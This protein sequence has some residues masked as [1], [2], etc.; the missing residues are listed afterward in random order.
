MLALGAQFSLLLRFRVSTAK[1]MR[2]R[3]NLL[4]AQ[5]M[6]DYDTPQN[7]HDKISIV[8]TRDLAK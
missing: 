4:R 2:V 3:W 7:F 8:E 1:M 6:V 5:Q